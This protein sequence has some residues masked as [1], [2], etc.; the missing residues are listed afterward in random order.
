MFASCRNSRFISRAV[1]LVEAAASLKSLSL[2]EKI[3]AFK[4]LRIN[5]PQSRFSSNAEIKAREG[6]PPDES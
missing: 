6:R 5:T 3:S 1:S 4:S 2:S